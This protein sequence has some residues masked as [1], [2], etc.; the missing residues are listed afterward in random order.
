MCLLTFAHEGVTPDIDKLRTGADN[1]PDGFGFAIHAGSHI[2]KCSGL[3]FDQVL[4]E[5]IKQ[6]AIH[7]GPMLFH[8]RIT[9]HGG[10]SKANCHPF[11]IGKDRL[12]VLAHNGMLPIA[13]DKGRSDTRILAEDMLPA[14]GGVAALNGKKFRKRLSKFATG[15]KLVI[16]TANRSSASPFWIINEDLGDW[17]NGVWWSN[18]S[19]RWAR[20][21]YVYTPGMYSSGWSPSEY[22]STTTTSTDPAKFD[23][24]EDILWHNWWVCNSCGASEYVDDFNVEEFDF[25]MC[26]ACWFCDENRDKCRCDHGFEIDDVRDAYTNTKNNYYDSLVDLD[27][28]A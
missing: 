12:S 20:R 13:E 16:L 24:A 7:S 26:G 28:W 14:E 9:T 2:V 15:S 4:D 8:S 17:E 11:Q 6:R 23:D 18:N 19:Y 3:D 25:C 22:T 1:N 5:F 10:T 21:P 27:E